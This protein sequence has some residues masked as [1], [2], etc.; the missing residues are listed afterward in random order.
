MSGDL[1]LFIGLLAAW[2][3]LLVATRRWVLARVQQGT[4]TVPA[5]LRLVAVELALMPWIALPWLLSPWDVAAL[6]LISGII[7]VSNALFG[8]LLVQ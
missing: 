6:A 7:L 5:A 8:R 4:M 1:L 3:V 2:V